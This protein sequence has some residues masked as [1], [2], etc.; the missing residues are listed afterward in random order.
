MIYNTLQ[1]KKNFHH[2]RYRAKTAPHF[3]PN[4]APICEKSIQFDEYVK[5]LRKML[6]L[7]AFQQIIPI[8]RKSLHIFFNIIHPFTQYKI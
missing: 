7:Y 6:L 1:A 5:L 3:D 2:R 4:T 8:H